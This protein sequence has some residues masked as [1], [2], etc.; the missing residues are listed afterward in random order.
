MMVSLQLLYVFAHCSLSSSLCFSQVYLVY[1]SVGHI[2]DAQ[3]DKQTKDRLVASLMA[4]TNAD[5]CIRPLASFFVCVLMCW[6]VSSSSLLDLLLHSLS[7]CVC[8]LLVAH[9][10]AA[11]LEGTC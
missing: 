2:I 5:V 9:I 7:V 11:L 8:L 3:Q 1:E 10:V 6:R 4:Y